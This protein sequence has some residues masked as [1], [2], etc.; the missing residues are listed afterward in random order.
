MIAKVGKVIAI[1]QYQEPEKQSQTEQHHDEMCECCQEGEQ[2]FQ[3]AIDRIFKVSDCPEDSIA[4]MMNLSDA[5]QRS[6][7]FT[8]NQY[9]GD[10]DDFQDQIREKFEEMVDDLE[11]QLD[12]FE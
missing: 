8:L 12:E 3:N 9:G 5:L 6:A 4:M 11:E 1:G 10:L 7:M 2:I